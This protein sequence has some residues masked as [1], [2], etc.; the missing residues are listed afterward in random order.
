[1]R[2]VSPTEENMKRISQVS[3]LLVLLLALLLLFTQAAFSESEEDF[4]VDAT[5]ENPLLHTNL[6]APIYLPVIVGR[7]AVSGKVTD[8]QSNPLSGVAIIDGSGLSTLTD[9]QGN[10]YLKGITSGEVALAPVK[11]GY[12]FA[13]SI[14]SLNLPEEAGVQDFTAVNACTNVITN[15]GFEN[16]AGWEL[17]ITERTARYSTANAHTGSRS[18]LTGILPG[19]LDKFSYSSTRQLVK[20]PSDA[21]NATLR[22]WLYPRSEESLSLALPEKL[23]GKIFG[24]DSLAGDVQ[25]VLVLDPFNNILETLLWMRSD[26]RVWSLYEFNLSMYAGENI[27]IHI[28]TYN[29]GAFGRTSMFVDDV[30]LEVCPASEPLPTPVPTVTG[31]P[32]ACFNEIS[33]SGFESTSA[34]EIP[35]TV[36][37]A[38]YATELAHSGSRSMR[39]GIVKTA[40]NIFSYSDAGQWVSIPSTAVDATLKL[41]VYS[42]TEEL[43]SNLALQKPS[44]SSDF[45][46]QAPA[47]DRQYLL[48]LD[49]FE[50]I[51]EIPLW[52]LSN[53]QNWVYNEFDL[54]QYAGRTIKIQ[55]GTFN[56]GGG[57]GVTAMYVDDL[58]VDICPSGAPTAT[59]TITP[60]PTL[61]P[62]ASPTP[63]STPTPPPGGTPT[64]TPVACTEGIDNGG[65]E[66]TSDWKIPITEFSAG[67]S[68]ALAHGGARSMRTGII[69]TIH[70]RYSYSDASQV[71]T[72]PASN[73][74]V[75][76]RMW[77]YPLSEEWAT[78][79]LPAIP[80]STVFGK[81]ALAS[82]VQYVLVLDQFDNWIGTLLW[83]RSDAQVWKLHTFDLSN[84][85]GE[86]IKIQFGTYNDGF[87]GVTAMYVDDVSL[88]MCP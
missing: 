24:K 29:D 70:N 63:T 78:L 22:V 38:G 21:S 66:A 65:F 77:I 74:E 2:W 20:I 3:L 46:I 11:E 37:D 16:D 35:N 85:S 10:Y 28:G 76:L 69:F 19:E 40:D 79:A 50:Q 34:W 53:D 56:T 31:T 88:Q 58:V 41:W 23:D 64:S 13:P 83:Q 42:I 45:R 15:S 75:T 59:P 17:P 67:Y 61:T 5:P 1:M 82:D 6:S 84:Y 87:G 8:L 36:Y 52:Q 68:T 27:K 51:L 32:P 14:V 80:Q 73:D 62:T 44:M 72:I 55:F 12:V 4:Q 7:P 39:T 18:V 33:N 57:L 43:T 9:S 54:G 25:Y 81:E 47:D 86:S 48:I 60:T 49:E 26:S 30:S 71:V